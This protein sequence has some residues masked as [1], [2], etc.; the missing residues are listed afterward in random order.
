M[1]GNYDAQ[2]VQ[3]SGGNRTPFPAGP[4]QL[5]ITKAE[6]GVTGN[7]DDKV[8]VDLKVA[9]GAHQGREVRF[10]TVTFLSKERPGAG[11][12]LH[13]LKQIGEPFEGEFAWDERRWI[14]RAILAHVIIEADQKGR[15]WNR[16]GDVLDSDDAVKV[17]NNR[18]AALPAP[19]ASAE[20][21]PF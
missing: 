3:P 15:D 14:G 2:G 17:H 5:I 16:I 10:H 21:V 19:A 20:E 7:G 11:M 12:A 6:Q 9:S 18:V 13:F 8:T 4:Y 1:P